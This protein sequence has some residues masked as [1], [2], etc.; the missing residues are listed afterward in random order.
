MGGGAGGSEDWPASYETR[1]RAAY[2]RNPV[3]QRAVRL[4]AEGLAQAV[5]I[6]SEAEA[7]GLIGPAL[8]EA[9]ASHLLL[10]GNAFLQ[11]LPDGAGR[12]MS[13]RCSARFR[14]GRWQ[15]LVRPSGGRRPI[16]PSRK[17]ISGRGEGRRQP[18]WAR[19]NSAI[20]IRRSRA[21]WA[22]NDGGD[23]PMGE[24]CELYRLTFRRSDGSVRMIET[25]TASRFYA[26]AEVAADVAAGGP[27]VE[28]MVAQIGD[29]APSP[30]TVLALTI[31]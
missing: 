3:A 16:P 30:D 4:V 11:I 25:D 17:R 5:V 28:I 24:G 23:V 7:A 1:V 15:R 8:L 29:H 10:H 12:L 26:D 2:L 20:M 9:A 14:A 21:G 18:C 22:W 13:A 19:S 31:G 6:G 27:A